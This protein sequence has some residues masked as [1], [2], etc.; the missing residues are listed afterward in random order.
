MNVPGI[1]TKLAHHFSHFVFALH[2]GAEGSGN[3][4]FIHFDVFYVLFRPELGP[5]GVEV[6]SE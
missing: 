4:E 6:P 3:G 2:P 5:R 1:R